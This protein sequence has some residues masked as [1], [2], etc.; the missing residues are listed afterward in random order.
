MR[1]YIEIQK[2]IPYGH[3]QDR[4]RIA[5]IRIRIFNKEFRIKYK[6]VI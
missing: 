2:A 4:V 3:F 6:V 1:K 5:C